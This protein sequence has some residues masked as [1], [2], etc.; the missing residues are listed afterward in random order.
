MKFYLFKY[1]VDIS[2]K[3]KLR[4]LIILSIKYPMRS[5][6]IFL[7]S[8]LFVFTGAYSHSVFIINNDVNINSNSAH[9]HLSTDFFEGFRKVDE[10]FIEGNIILENN[11]EKCNVH[12]FEYSKHEIDFDVY[13]SSDITSLSIFDKSDLIGLGPISSNKVYRLDYYDNR[14]IESGTGD[15][16]FV[17]NIDKSEIKPDYFSLFFKYLWMGVEHIIYG[18]DHIFFILGFF[19]AATTL[20]TLLKS[21]S[22]FTVSHSITLTLAALGMFLVPASIVEPLIALS[23]VIVGLL[24]LKGGLADWVFSFGLIF[25]FGLFHGL[26][27][28][29]SISEIGFP[30]SGFVTSLIGF[31]LGVELG[32]LFVVL[33]AIGVFY[34]IRKHTSHEKTAKLGLSLLVILGGS[35]WL[36]QRLF[37]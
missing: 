9:F 20:L 28:A 15:L 23:I 3:Y 17:V 37:F 27:F 4:Y 33:I 7:I 13:C 31:N 12:N 6:F 29:G 14:K 32:Q 30:Q 1:I 22:G 10:K 2:S 19:L 25:V 11:G 5:L 35:F 21:I 16:N 18:L 36:F 8:L 34:L 26:G 24:A